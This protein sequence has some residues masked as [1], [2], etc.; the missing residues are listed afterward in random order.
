MWLFVGWNTALESA[1]DHYRHTQSVRMSDCKTLN[2]HVC[3][4][5][6][7]VMQTNESAFHS[8]TLK[9]NVRCSNKC[10]GIVTVHST[11]CG[12]SGGHVARL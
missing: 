12:G 8:Q 4:D 11:H 7:V 10:E 3:A 6:S 1:T 5:K 9:Q 2:T